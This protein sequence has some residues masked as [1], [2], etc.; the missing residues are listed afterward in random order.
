MDSRAPRGP[1][2]ASAARPA[3]RGRRDQ[4]PRRQ[5][6]LYSVAHAERASLSAVSPT[7]SGRGERAGAARHPVADIEPVRKH[8][9]RE[10]YGASRGGPAA[11][12]VSLGYMT[13]RAACRPRRR[14]RG[15]GRAHRLRH[16]LGH[17]GLRQR[18]HRLAVRRPRMFS[19][20]AEHRAQKLVALQFFILAP[21]VGY[22]SVRALIDGDHPT[23][24]GWASRCRVEH[25]RH[26]LPGHRQAAH[27]R[28]D[29][30]GR[31]QGRRP[32]EHALRVPRRRA[33]AGPAR[34]RGV[35][36]LVARPARRAAHRRR[37]RPGGPDAWRGEGCC[38]GNPLEGAGFADDCQDDC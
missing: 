12:W 10:T 29:R 36:R 9:D 22:E 3:W 38:V 31:H 7:R 5:V 33:A 26:A 16:R 19:A 34:Q 20:T 8:I 35:R 14:P 13:R 27:R 18:H 28:P 11:S 1:G 30:L 4:P 23:S 32:P 37:G 2:L 6:V 21:Y 24:P 25:G 15:I 17:R